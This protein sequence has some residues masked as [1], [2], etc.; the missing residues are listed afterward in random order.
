MSQRVN[1]S[2]AWPT[3]AGR[4]DAEGEGQGGCPRESESVRSDARVRAGCLA[5]KDSQWGD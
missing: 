2:P 4:R 1:V 5:A 3:R